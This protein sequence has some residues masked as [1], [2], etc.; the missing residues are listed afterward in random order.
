MVPTQ[1]SAL[2]DTAFDFETAA[3][4]QHSKRDKKERRVAFS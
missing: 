3:L 4:W 1:D 2:L